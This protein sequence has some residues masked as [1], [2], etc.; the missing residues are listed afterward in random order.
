MR[1]DAPQS[2]REAARY[3]ID[4]T[5]AAFSRRRAR[6]WK[7]G[8]ASRELAEA[9]GIESV[10]ISFSRY[11]PDP[12]MVELRARPRHQAT[13]VHRGLSI[14]L[15]AAGDFRA[16]GQHALDPDPMAASL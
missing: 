6:T 10:L 9:A 1:L 2:P 14:G 5:S 7:V 13:E 8:C 3:R 15:D 11:E 4:S 12:L 16:T